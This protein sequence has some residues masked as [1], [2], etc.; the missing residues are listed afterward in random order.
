[1]ESIRTAIAPFGLMLTV[2]SIVAVDSPAAAAA[3]ISWRGDARVAMREA[4]ATGK[5]LLIEVGADWCHFSKKMEK[6]TFS[7]PTVANHVRNCFVP[8]RID[9]DADRTITRQLGVRTFPTTI[10]LSPQLELLASIKGFRTAEQ[11]R[12][13]L[14]EICNHDRAAQ[15][16]ARLQLSVFDNYCPVTTLD[17]GTATKGSREFHLEYRD[18]DVFFA[19]QEARTQFAAQPSRYWPVADGFCSARFVDGNKSA[20]GSW[21]YAVRYANRIW[22]FSSAEKLE[23][24]KQRPK[25][26]LDFVRR[27]ADRE[28]QTALV[29]FRPG[30]KKQTELTQVRQ[31]V[32]H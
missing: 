16:S 26:Y 21:D 29:P 5:P 11:L 25:H 15:H 10:V 17:T 30:S 19:S 20:K 32:V 24:F 12:S 4:T 27:V 7:N 2:I 18:Y 28:K 22:L 13:D 8:V 6:E 9:A 31:S 1:M 14:A 23:D 3:P